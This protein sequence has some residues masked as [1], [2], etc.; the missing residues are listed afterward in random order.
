MNKYGSATAAYFIMLHFYVREIAAAPDNFLFSLVVF[1][2]DILINKMNSL[3]RLRGVELSPKSL[4]FLFPSIFPLFSLYYLLTSL[5]GN[6]LKI[7]Q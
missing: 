1:I 7:A 4:T 6:G 5:H 3:T 2:S